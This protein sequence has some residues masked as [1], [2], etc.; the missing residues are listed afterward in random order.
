MAELASGNKFAPQTDQ[1]NIESF[2]TDEIRGFL[3]HPSAADGSGLVLTHGAGSNCEAPLLMGLAAV[4][5][6][7]GSLVLRMDLPFR[8]KRPKGPPLPGDAALD[9]AG[10][11]QASTL[12]RKMAGGPLWLAGHSYGGRQATMLV[13]DEPKA[14]DAL[15]LLSYPLH[16][17]ARPDQAR[18]AHWPTL[19]T[20]LF[21]VHGTKDPFG[22]IDEL[23][24]SLPLIPAPTALATLPG[25]GHDLRRGKFALE[26]L[27]VRPFRDFA[28]AT[29]RSKK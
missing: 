26:D 18:T 23:Q 24:S 28:A 1:V 14:A 25:A 13:A 10:L 17:P 19:R 27:V 7:A 12:L 2:G 4:F 11:L 5:A 16:P 6:K 20:P 15:L 3:H 29:G 22:S 21:F 9:R 8:R